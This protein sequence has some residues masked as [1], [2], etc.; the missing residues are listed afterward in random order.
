M[1]KDSLN[2]LRKLIRECKKEGVKELEAD[3]VRII[4]EDGELN[5][6]D[7]KEDAGLSA[8]NLLYAASEGILPFKKGG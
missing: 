7:D 2:H 5:I 1:N 4:F 8:N 6:E 3:G